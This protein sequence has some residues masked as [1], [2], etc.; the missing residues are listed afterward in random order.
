MADKNNRP[1][2]KDTYCCEITTS[3]VYVDDIGYIKHYGLKMYNR[4]STL[5]GKRGEYCIVEDVTPSF[6][7][8]AELK[9][10]IDELAIYPVHLKDVVEDFLSK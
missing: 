1:R 5:A 7:D 8:I 2:S 3:M 6:D 4:N 10:L 9:R